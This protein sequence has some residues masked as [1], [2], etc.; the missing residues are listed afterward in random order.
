MSSSIFISPP[1]LGP[2]RMLL[3]LCRVAHLWSCLQFVHMAFCYRFVSYASHCALVLGGPS[4]LLREHA[5]VNQ[6]PAAHCLWIS[7][8][9]KDAL[10]SSMSASSSRMM[11]ILTHVPLWTYESF[12]LKWVPVVEISASLG[13]QCLNYLLKGLSGKLWTAEHSFHSAWKSYILIFC[14]C[15]HCPVSYFFSNLERMWGSLLFYLF[16]VL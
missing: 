10:L 3:K 7:L 11:S 4:L 13:L 5:V 15:C 9:R 14:Q 12:S 8:P 1:V 2:S 6:E 16:I